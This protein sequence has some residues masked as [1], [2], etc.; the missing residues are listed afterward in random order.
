MNPSENAPGIWFSIQSALSLNS[1]Q[2]VPAEYSK[3]RIYK[4]TKLELKIN[5]EDAT[6]PHRI[7]V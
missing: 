7:L 4:K 3:L 2:P 6:H 5:V 1:P